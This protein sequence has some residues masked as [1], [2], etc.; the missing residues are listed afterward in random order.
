MTRD[1]SS[2]FPRSAA[3]LVAFY[4]AGVYEGREIERALTYLKKNQPQ[5]NGRN[6]SH[7]YYGQY[8]AVQGMW[9]AG[10]DHWSTWFP[11]AR[12][13]MLSRQR[14]DGSWPDGN[15]PAYATAMACVMLQVPNNM[16]PIFQR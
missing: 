6:F 8:Y 14:P 3:G 15:G 12:D 7:Y 9:Q 2:A 1:R 5:V 4:S 16:V 11:A 13:L 10:G